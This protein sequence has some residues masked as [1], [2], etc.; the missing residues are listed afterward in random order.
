MQYCNRIFFFQIFQFGGIYLIK[1]Y[2]YNAN[3]AANT[4]LITKD[5]THT[6]FITEF[7][8]LTT[9]Y[10]TPIKPSVSF[11]WRVCCVCSPWRAERWSL[12]ACACNLRA[13]AI[14]SCESHRFMVEAQR[15]TLPST[16]CHIFPWAFNKNPNR[17]AL[18][19]LLMLFCTKYM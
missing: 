12:K 9:K 3:K 1:Q 18:A 16:M 10:L 6:L 11:L 19:C 4:V 17:M 2:I 5:T 14:H 15:D 7:I 13:S 8:Q